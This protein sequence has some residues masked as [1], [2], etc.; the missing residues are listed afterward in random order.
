MTCM[1]SKLL[2]I[3]YMNDFVGVLP[4][5]LAKTIYRYGVKKPEDI[6]LILNAKSSYYSYKALML[7]ELLKSLPSDKEAP[8]MIILKSLI[9]GKNEASFRCSE[10]YAQEVKKQ[11]FLH[12]LRS[13]GM[14][15]DF[16]NK[17]NY[18]G[19]MKSLS[20]IALVDSEDN[21]LDF[22]ML[23]LTQLEFTDD[24][25]RATD[26]FGDLLEEDRLELSDDLEELAVQ[27]L[28][29]GSF[30]GCLSILDY[31]VERKEYENKLPQL[32]NLQGI[33]FIE[34]DQIKKAK[35]SFLTGMQKSEKTVEPLLLVNFITVC[36]QLDDKKSALKGLSLYFDLIAPDHK[37]L[38][39]DSLEEAISTQ[40]IQK[41]ELPLNVKQ[42]MKLGLGEL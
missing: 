14:S 12:I 33:C 27:Q 16:L 4:I 35:V 32:Y 28:Q 5:T 15:E 6:V 9:D 13:D 3:Y 29:C 21:P 40:V 39:V 37:H 30:S 1:S 42:F 7:E 20:N 26:I 38:I 19:F 36:L 23:D 24:Q 11:I 22:K 31:A 34:T 25:L 8:L 41:N 18:N 10:K 2:C 17:I